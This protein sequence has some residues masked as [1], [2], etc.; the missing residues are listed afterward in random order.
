M[1]IVNELWHFGS[2]LFFSTLSSAHT[3]STGSELRSSVMVTS[4]GVP[5]TCFRCVTAP[6]L[7][8]NPPSCVE[9]V[10]MILNVELTTWTLP[11]E[12]P[13]NRLSEPAVSVVMSAPYSPPIPR[14]NRLCTFFLE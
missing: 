10:R 7:C 14:V 9:K 13:R 8:V 2:P 6:P 11:S 3:F 12:V 1:L 4:S 5:S